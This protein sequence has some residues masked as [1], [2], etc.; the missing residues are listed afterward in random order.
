MNFMSFPWRIC[1]TPRFPVHTGHISFP[2]GTFSGLLSLGIFP[3]LLSQG[4]STSNSWSHSPV[5][6]RI[7][8]YHGIFPG[9]P[10]EII[11]HLLTS[12]EHSWDIC[13]FPYDI[14]C[15]PSGIS[16]STLAY[17]LV[18]PGEF[19]LHWDISLYTPM[20]FP[21]QPLTLPVSPRDISS[22]LWGISCPYWDISLPVHGNSL[23][24]LEHFTVCPWTFPCQPLIFAS[25]PRNISRLPWDISL[26]AHGY[27]PAEP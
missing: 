2:S 3:G 21:C 18:C 16:R 19:P 14:S 7:T 13:R 25:L 12:Q 22:L 5:W 23:S 26:H 1:C 20:T 8:G 9:V 11:R 17:F 15:Q 24:A 27:F 6:M 10:S 4:H